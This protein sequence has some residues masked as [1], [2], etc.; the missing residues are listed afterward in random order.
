MRRRS[1]ICEDEVDDKKM[2]EEIETGVVC[3]VA[4]WSLFLY[5]WRCVFCGFERERKREIVEPFFVICCVY[6]WCIYVCRVL[7]VYV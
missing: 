4:E 6:V 1:A 7:C 2:G 3:F 5:V